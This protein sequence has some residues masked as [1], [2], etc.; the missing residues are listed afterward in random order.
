MNK[1]TNKRKKKLLT[2]NEAIV[3]AIT[4]FLDGV[5]EIEKMKLHVS[6]KLINSEREDCKLLVKEQLQMVA[7]FVKVLKNKDSSS[8]S[9]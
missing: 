5:L 6:E 1:S 4:K 9:K 7:L 2:S 8:S 3:A